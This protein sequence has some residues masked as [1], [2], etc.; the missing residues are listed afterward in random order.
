VAEPDPAAVAGAGAVE[1]T[2]QEKD[3]K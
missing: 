1:N 3:E 2:D